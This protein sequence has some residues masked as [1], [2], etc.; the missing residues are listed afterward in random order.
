MV[1]FMNDKNYVQPKP[2]HNVIMENRRMLNISGVLD[3][4]SFDER[5]IVLNT[6]LGGL[7]IRGLNL[8]ISHLE[9]STGEMCI[10]GEISDIV[11]SEEE[12]EPVGF[13]SRLFR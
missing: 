2:A 6:Q 7:T 4:D 1:S 5:S 9:Q 13:W 3:V 10:D 8:H 12:L 11:Y